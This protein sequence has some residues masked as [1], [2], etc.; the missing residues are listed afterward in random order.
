MSLLKIHLHPAQQ[1]LSKIYL[2]QIL[3]K[4]LILHHLK[5]LKPTFL[6]CVNA[7]VFQ[8]TALS[9]LPLITWRTFYLK[10]I[11]I[12][13]CNI[14]CGSSMTS[15]VDPYPFIESNRPKYKRIWIDSIKGCGLTQDVIDSPHC[16]S[17]HTQCNLLGNNNVISICCL[18][19]NKLMVW[20]TIIFFLVRYVMGLLCGYN[21]VVMRHTMLLHLCILVETPFF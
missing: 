19:L 7:K 16:M 13:F 1:E 17:W 8:T 9:A 3:L 12:F 4:R 5:F 18:A 20:I 6:I 21:V 10:H 2:G 11:N 15:W 14:Q